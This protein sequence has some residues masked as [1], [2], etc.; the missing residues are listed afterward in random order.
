MIYPSSLPAPQKLK[1]IMQSM[2]ALDAILC[3]EWQYRYY[4]YDSGWGPSE[5]MGS[6]RN[7]SGDDVFVLF[8]QSGC[9]LKGFSHEFPDSRFSSNMFYE[10]VPDA[11]KAGADEPAF[12]PQNVS[13]C[14][15]QNLSGGGWETSIEER[16][17]DPNV[18]FLIQDLD[19]QASTFQKFAVEYHEMQIAMQPLQAVFEHVSITE[20]LAKSLNPE[21]EYPSLLS[22]LK[23]IGYPCDVKPETPKKQKRFLKKLFDRR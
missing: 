7:G 15:W 21:I 19:G 6:I 12:S 2:A 14:A 22:D 20:K 13:F 17:L 5:Q 10:N 1:S 11:F 23:Q 4:S 16:D 18:F 3:P 8:N 9:F